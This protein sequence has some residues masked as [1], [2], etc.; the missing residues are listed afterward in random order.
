MNRI[1]S[2]FAQSLSLFIKWKSV[3]NCIE[4]SAYIDKVLSGVHPYVLNCQ[5]H[6][7][8]SSYVYFYHLLRLSMDQ[9]YPI[10]K[11][12]TLL[13]FP[14]RINWHAKHKLSHFFLYSITPSLGWVSCLVL[15]NL[16]FGM[17]ITG[18]TPPFHWK[19]LSRR[20]S[21]ANKMNSTM[22]RDNISVTKRMTWILLDIEFA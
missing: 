2:M 3:L 15:L 18:A 21:R 4:S 1:H 12:E 19:I 22:K 9:H 17:I 14:K 8:Y 7:C 16:Y 11:N 6:A 10:I 13:C 20:L 5:M